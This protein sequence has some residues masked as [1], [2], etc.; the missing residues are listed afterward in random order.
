MRRKDALKILPLL[1]AEDPAALARFYREARAAGT[2]DH[3]N[4]V[5]TYDNGQEGDYHFLV[6]EYVDGRSLEVI[7]QKF[8]PMD[9][10]RAAAYIRQAAVGLQHIHQAGLIHRDIKP[11]NLLLDRGGTVKILDMGLVRFFQDHSDTL[12]QE[13][14]PSA[15]L[16]TADYLSPEQAL[17]SHDVDTRT[18]VYALGATF[19]FLLCGRPPFDGKTVSEKL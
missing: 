17:N 13:Y 6:M 14:D 1:K 5:R 3:P 19:Y 16:G 11:A 15:I 2:L 10:S 4:I 7:V 18:D 9:V 8:G 12:T